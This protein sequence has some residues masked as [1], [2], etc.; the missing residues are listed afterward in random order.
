VEL[1]ISS[2]VDFLALTRTTISSS[3]ELEL[4]LLEEFVHL[5]EFWHSFSIWKVGDSGPTLEAPL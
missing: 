1:G 2:S 4:L 5:G 3:S